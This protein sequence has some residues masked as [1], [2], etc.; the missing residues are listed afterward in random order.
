MSEEK[1]VNSQDISRIPEN[2]KA[3]VFEKQSNRMFS[4]SEVDQMVAKLSRKIEEKY[5]DYDSVKKE[6]ESLRKE[7][8]EKELAEKSELEKT[9]INL[10]KIN[11]E[12]EI[13]K[14]ENSRFKLEN[15]KNSILQEPRFAKLPR[16][17]KNLVVASENSDEVRQSAEDVFREFE[18]D[19]NGLK[20]ENFGKP[21]EKLKGN[22]SDSGFIT[23]GKSGMKLNELVATKIKNRFNRGN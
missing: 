21:I 3:D 22:N 14:Q 2:Q 7:R 20:S 13:T 6:I 10:D 19:H 23:E 12:L 5:N 1:D 11:K 16:A 4:Q 8:E 9:Q 15:I 18:Q 17:Y